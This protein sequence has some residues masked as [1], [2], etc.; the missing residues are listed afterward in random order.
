MAHSP[1]AETVETI[2]VTLTRRRRSGRQL[3]AAVGWSAGTTSR[4][5]RAESPLTVDELYA[6][7]SFLDVDPAE[8]LPNRGLRELELAAVS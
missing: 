7:A 5:L 1:G 4:K 8:L 3:A 2:R 6:A